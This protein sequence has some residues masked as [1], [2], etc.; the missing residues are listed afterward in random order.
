[1]PQWQGKS[2][3]T[4]WGYQIF[5]F[6]CK[7]WGIKPAYF[8]LVFV[9]AWY[10]LFSFSSTRNIYSYM[11][12]RQKFGVFRSIISVY[13]NYLVFGQTLIDKVVV[14][15]RIRHPFTFEFD[16]EEHLRTMMAGGRGGILLSG[17][18]GNWEAAG[19]LLERLNVKVNVVMFDGEHE[20]IKDKLENAIGDKNF[21]IIPVKNDLSHVYAIHQVLQNNELVCLHA[22]RYMPDSKTVLKNF[23]GEDAPFPAGPFE[24]AASLKVPVSVVFAFKD[25]AFHYHLC[26]SPCV[27]KTE[28]E[29]KREF[30]ER[31]TELFVCDFENKLRRYPLQWFNYYDFWD[32]TNARPYH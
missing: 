3:G 24:L 15:G 9:A 10:F 13:K 25:S 11:R 20:Q 19:H 22:D 1:M 31:L 28:D 12:K 2:K 26:G 4:S 29:T 7:K 30:V 23:F 32:K 5:I 8:L 17:H 16:G 27:E 6:T 14:M 18:A 21:R